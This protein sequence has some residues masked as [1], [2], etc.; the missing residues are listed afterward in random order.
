[1]LENEG[2]IEYKSIFMRCDEV[3]K[4]A[5]R[6]VPS[7]VSIERYKSGMEKIWAD[8]QKASG[9]F[10][11]SSNEEVTSYFINRF[12]SES[13][14]LTE[15]CFFLK[16]NKSE[17]YFGTCMAW[18]KKKDDK[19]IPV[20]HWLAVDSEYCG[21][22]YARVL[23]TKVMKFFE[24]NNYNETVFLHTQPKS[25]KAIKLYSDFGFCLTAK[26]VY[27]IAAN[28]SEE[29]ISLLEK[30]MKDE[31]ILVLKQRMIL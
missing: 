6:T 23:I 29:S 8:I 2:D 9:E 17:K 16:D 13:I 18:E 12:G 27:G 15:R 14:S 11:E 24:I 5:Y 22:G 1:M 25:F 21:K 4:D 19:V 3:N 7:L 20:L 28:E 31:T 26:D 30:Y 10:P